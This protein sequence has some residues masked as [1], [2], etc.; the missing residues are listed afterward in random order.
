MSKFSMTKQKFINQ[1]LHHFA[2]SVSKEKIEQHVKEQFIWHIFS[3]KLIKTNDLLVGDA[4]KK[5]FNETVKTDC[6]FCDMFGNGGV[7]DKL[8]PQYDTAASKAQYF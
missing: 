1:W 7:T 2:K 8:S 5:A 3:W 6:I 4:A